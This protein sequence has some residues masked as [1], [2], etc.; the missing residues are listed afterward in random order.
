MIKQV[1]L[2]PGQPSPET[3]RS[4]SHR[5]LQGSSLSSVSQSINWICI[6]ATRFS[7]D[8]QP[9]HVQ[10]LC[11]RDRTNRAALSAKGP[12]ALHVHHSK[13][14][15][16]EINEDLQP[17]EFVDVS[18]GELEACVIILSPCTGSSVMMTSSCGSGALHVWDKLGVLQAANAETR[19]EKRGCADEASSIS[20]SMLNVVF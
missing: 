12:R 14:S 19:Q 8:L 13:Q 5:D 4:S 20:Q 1:A 17:T 16:Q 9:V 2:S 15:E 11:L 7:A 6:P 3:P 18:S 10:S